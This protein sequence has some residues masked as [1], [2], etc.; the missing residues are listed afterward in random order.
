[1]WGG[2]TTTEKPICESRNYCAS[3]Q[4]KTQTLGS[5][6]ISSFFP[7]SSFF[8]FLSLLFSI[9]HFLFLFFFE[10]DEPWHYFWRKKERKEIREKTVK[11]SR[12]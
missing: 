5:M 12:R 8:F 3:I 7:F 9:L 4:I 1:M 6:S 2:V 10:A 11:R